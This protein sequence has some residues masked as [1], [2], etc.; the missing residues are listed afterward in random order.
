MDSGEQP[1]PQY[2]VE[3]FVYYDPIQ[4]LKFS[5]HP[6]TLDAKIE[7]EGVDLEANSVSQSLLQL[8]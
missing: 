3:E 2:E 4:K 7:E 1:E 5:F 8:R 6:V